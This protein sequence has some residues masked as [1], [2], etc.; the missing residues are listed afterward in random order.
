[1]D[2][3]LA[4]E[5][6]NTED[7]AHLFD[8]TSELLIYELSVR[9]VKP[10]AKEESMYWISFTLNNPVCCNVLNCINIYANAS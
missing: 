4:K 1:M 7:G 10:R 2:K 5:V 6:P 8:N 9:E 3:S